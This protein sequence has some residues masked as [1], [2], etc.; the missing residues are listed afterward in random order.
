M[1]TRSRSDESQMKRSP[2]A[3]REL[4]VEAV[5]EHGDQLEAEERLDPGE[6][7]AAFL[8][9]VRGRGVEFH[10]LFFSGAE[11]LGDSHHALTCNFRA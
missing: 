5:V 9:Q 7:H 2:F 3:R 6:H 11:R 1:L 4:V 8:E 10:R